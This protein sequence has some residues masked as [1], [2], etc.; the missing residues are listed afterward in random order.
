[1]IITECCVVCVRKI[2][3]A[4][5]AGSAR[6]W[7]Y[8]QNIAQR[9]LPHLIEQHPLMRGVLVQSDQ[10][11]VLCLVELERVLRD[12]HLQVAGH[13]SLHLHK[14]IHQLEDGRDVGIPS[15]E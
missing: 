8:H 12:G 3:C 7:C 2:A 6:S 10:Y 4:K 11:N 9:A 14:H 15:C 13:L 1:M 5:N